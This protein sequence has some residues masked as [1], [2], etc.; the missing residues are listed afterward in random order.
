MAPRLDLEER[1]LKMILQIE[2]LEVKAVR[3]KARE[4]KE[5]MEARKR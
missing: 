2:L 1:V 3:Q 4:R 5:N